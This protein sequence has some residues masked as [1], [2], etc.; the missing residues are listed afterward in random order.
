[1]RI[2][3]FFDQNIDP[4]STYAALLSTLLFIWEVIKWVGRKKIHIECTPNMVN[5]GTSLVREDLSELKKNN[6]EKFIFVRIT[7]RGSVASEVSHLHFEYYPN[8]FNQLFY[9]ITKLVY[10][11]KLYYLIYKEKRRIVIKTFE[12]KYLK[13]GETCIHTIPQNEEINEM[14]SIGILTICIYSSISKNSIMVKVP[15]LKLQR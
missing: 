4:I 2:E 7:N 1:M 5:D 10:L 6:Y 9:R 11:E 12:K 8:L 3:F 13:P 15:P 14:S